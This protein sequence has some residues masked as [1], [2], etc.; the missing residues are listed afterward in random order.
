MV[1]M[2]KL[3][4][5]GLTPG[6]AILIGVLLVIF[7]VVLI[8]NLWPSTPNTTRT[9]DKKRRRP[10]REVAN[11]PLSRKQNS[12][13]E[14][15]SPR[16]FIPWPSIAVEKAVQHD[17]FGIPTDL[18]P[19]KPEDPVEEPAADR[20]N[21]L[22]ILRQQQLAERKEKLKLLRSLQESR[23]GITLVTPDEK[24]IAV[25]NKKLH[26]GDLWQGFRIVEIHS[27]GRIVVD[28]D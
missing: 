12:Q 20:Q 8:T 27:D 3:E 14:I 18:L 28:I 17:P 22:E 7:V 25:G 2:K 26:V 1:D 5:L 24:V 13:Y 9:A 21:D 16:N 19:D 15:R 6:K 4:S 11:T 23:A 10:I